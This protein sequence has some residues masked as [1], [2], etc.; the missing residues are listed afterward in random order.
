MVKAH[1]SIGGLSVDMQGH[2]SSGERIGDKPVICA[3][4]SLMAQSLIKSVEDMAVV[5]IESLE[6]GDV[7]FRINP[8]AGYGQACAWK[9]E[10]LVDGLELLQSGYPGSVDLLVTA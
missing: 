3:A 7:R 5:V 2:D 10:M 4:M 1:I 6:P 8:K 9:L